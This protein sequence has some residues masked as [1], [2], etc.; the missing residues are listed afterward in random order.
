MALVQAPGVFLQG[1]DCC[2]GETM[3]GEM[4][5]EPHYFTEASWINKPEILLSSWPI[6]KKAKHIGRIQAGGTNMA[7][8]LLARLT[9]EGWK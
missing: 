7:K 8:K 2:I 5:R 9:E 6:N 4:N 1:T 3:K